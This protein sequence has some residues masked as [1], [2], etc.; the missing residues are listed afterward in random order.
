MSPSYWPIVHICFLLCRKKV[1]NHSI[2]SSFCDTFTWLLLSWSYPT[3]RKFYSTAFV[4]TAFHFPCLTPFKWFIPAGFFIVDVSGFL[5]HQQTCS[6]N[7]QLWYHMFYHLF[8][9]WIQL[10]PEQCLEVRYFNHDISFYVN[11]VIIF[12]LAR[13]SFI[14]L[15]LASSSI[16]ALPD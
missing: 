14:H 16:L 9:L 7:C 15:I 1:Y 3:F 10:R 12:L 13:K 11:T 4:C 8:T 2:F 5:L 6:S